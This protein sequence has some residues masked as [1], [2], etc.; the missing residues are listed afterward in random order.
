MSIDVDYCKMIES[1]VKIRFLC[2]SD[3]TD[4]GIYLQECV[5]LFLKRT[6]FSY[7]TILYKVELFKVFSR[8]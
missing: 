8:I 6:T 5:S 3:Y 2:L 1:G 4:L 7:A